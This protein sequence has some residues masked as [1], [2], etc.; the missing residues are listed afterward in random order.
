MD[1][2]DIDKFRDPIWRIGN[3]YSIRRREGKVTLFRPRPQQQQV[4]EMIFRQRLKRI[5]ILKARQLGFSTLLGIICADELCWTTGK[6]ISLID[7]TQ[8][9][10][11]QK[12]RNIV[13]LAYDSLHS[14]L[15]TRFI[16]D[17][18]N[19]GQFFQFASTNTILRKRAPFSPVPMPVA[20]RI[21]SFGFQ[22][23]G[24]SSAKI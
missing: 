13:A 21:P 4:L 7:K 2:S 5:V 11:R 18:S 16:V 12:L 8:E 10:A 22:N 17:R 14:E 20:A 23:G 9:D 24:M 3:L 1:L 6:Q 15:K 19:A